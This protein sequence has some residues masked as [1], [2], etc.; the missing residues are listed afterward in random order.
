LEELERV[1][2][3]MVVKFTYELRPFFSEL[4][5]K[6]WYWNKYKSLRS[7]DLQA[8]YIV[9]TLTESWGLISLILVGGLK[10]IY[11]LIAIAHLSLL[12]TSLCSNCNCQHYQIYCL[13]AIAQ[14]SLLFTSLCSNC[15]WQHYQ[16]K[17]ARLG[18]AIT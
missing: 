12:F 18:Q 11:C 5:Y 6:T 1:L 2:N 3:I 7:F 10:S 14:L 13:I 16:I 4:M 17:N 9:L 15:N 8:L